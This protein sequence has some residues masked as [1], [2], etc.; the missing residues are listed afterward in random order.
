[1]FLFINKILLVYIN[2]II[3]KKQFYPLYVVMKPIQFFF[4]FDNSQQ[5]LNKV[6]QQL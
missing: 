3:F 4:F 2:K 5:L 1:M 6:L